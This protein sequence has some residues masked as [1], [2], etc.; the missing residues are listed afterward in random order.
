[1]SLKGLLAHPSIYI[2]LQKM[3][4][5][6]QLRYRCLDAADIQPGEVV[7]DVG[8]GPAYYF[9]RVPL[10]VT[11]H[12]FD[13]DATYIDWA[14]RNWGDRGTFHVGIFDPA[15][16]QQL[17]APDAILLLGLLHHLSDQDS[18]DLLRLCAEIIAPGGRVVSV[19]TAFVPGQ[20]R[21]SRWMSENDRGEHVR[22]PEGFKALARKYFGTVHAEVVST[23]SPMPG[24]H[25]MMKL[26]NPAVTQHQHQRQRQREVHSSGDEARPSH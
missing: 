7:V 25:V 5:A 19:D 12:G 17:P 23:V 15:A 20:G 4:G 10:P 14:R 16:A 26:A 8:C 9:D 6:D 1:M 21:R 3:V 24:A 13:T 11:Y 18:S 22:E 2:G